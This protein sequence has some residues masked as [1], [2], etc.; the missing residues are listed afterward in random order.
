[1]SEAFEKVLDKLVESFDDFKE[2]L[3][4]IEENV[5]DVKSVKSDVEELKIKNASLESKASSA[6]KRLD[7]LENNQTWLWRTVMGGI[8]VGGIGLLFFVVQTFIKS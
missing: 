3:I 5:R 8:I 2:R 6:H 4:R 7:K 1:M